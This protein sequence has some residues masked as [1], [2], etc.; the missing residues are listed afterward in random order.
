M[1]AE[2]S[3]RGC[4]L[5]SEDLLTW[6]RL[7]RGL[8]WVRLRRGLTWVRLRRGLTWV[9]L[10]RTG[11]VLALATLTGCAAI[12]MKVPQGFLQLETPRD[13]LK[14]TSPDEAKIWVREFE[15]P[16]KG[17]LAF[18]AD[19][20]RKDLTRNRGYELVE[21]G[22]TRDVQGRPG[23]WMQFELV[24]GGEPQGYLVAVFVIEGSSANTIRVAELVARK[25][26]FDAS[27]GA[28]RE[29]LATLAP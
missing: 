14:A 9:R 3:R 19:V 11:V 20:L 6:V 7:R 21:E 10:R 16:N 12:S 28:V 17:D 25:P 13:E 18:W 23:T 4:S 15:D 2:R 22:A 27:V 1:T 8:T 24:L 26:V 29:A 5:P